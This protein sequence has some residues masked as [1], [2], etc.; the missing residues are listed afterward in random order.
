VPTLVFHQRD[1]LAPEEGLLDPALK[2]VSPSAIK[3]WESTLIRWTRRARMD[4][5]GA[6][7]KA[8]AERAHA[9][10]EVVA[11]FHQAGVPLLTGSDS[12]NPWNV[13]G[14]SLHAELANF[15]AA[16]MTPYQALRCATAEVGRFLG[17]GSGTLAV[18]KRADLL[19]TRSNPLRDLRA[20]QEIEAVAVNGYYLSRAD[21]DRM[22][23][24]RAALAAAPAKLPASAVAGGSTW[25]ERIVGAEAGRIG[26]R[27]S[28][29]PDGGWLI[30]E[31]HAAALPRRHVERR[32]SRLE[33]DADF[34]L[35]SCEYTIDSFAGSERGTIKRSTDGYAIEATG[36][37]GWES[38]HTL[39]T[40]PLLPSE[41][42]TAT[43]WPLLVQRSGQARILDVEEGALIVREVLFKDGELKVSRPTHVTEQRYRFADGK[44]LGMEETMP[45]LWLREL[46]PA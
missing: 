16:G 1:A 36:I 31:R 32:S 43:L 7:R 11:I 33:L 3:D 29:L 21:L 35:R 44:F 27:H 24:Q 8:A 9:F 28:R 4:D 20:L 12:L 26:L 19:L 18:G 46:V 42:L 5:V 25:I 17:D 10:Q 13:P 23:A 39:A 41:R 14:A 37:D 30:E 2:Y 38:R 45:L 15:A 34:K 6:W 22:L 40:E